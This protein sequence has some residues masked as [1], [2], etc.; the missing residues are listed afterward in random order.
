MRKSTMFLRLMG[1][2]FRKRKSRVAIALLAIVIGAAVI[3]G[4]VNVYYDINLK[5]SKEFRSYGANLIITPVGI[6]GENYIAQQEID[7]AV[8]MLPKGTLVGFAPYLY[9]VAQVESQRLV[10][11]GTWFDQ[12]SKVSPYWEVTG[13][14]LKERNPAGKALVG[15]A[16]AQKLDLAVGRELVLT[17]EKTGRQQ[18][19]MIEGIVKSGGT[20]DNQIFISLTQAQEL[21][22]QPHMVNVAYLS[23]MAKGLELE[24]KA[25]EIKGKF[26]GLEV[27]PIKQI[28]RSEAVIL[29]KIRSLVY[30]VVGIILLSTL[31]CVATTM[32]TMVVERKREIGLKKALGAQNRSIMIEFLS[33]G[34]ILGLAGGIVGISL[35][36]FLAQLIGQS[37]FNS[38]ITFRFSVIPLVLLVSLLVAGIACILPVKMAADVEPA[39]VLKGE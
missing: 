33:E 31:L 22:N 36:Y 7:Q 18:Q 34:S 8:G 17:D 30:L 32:M 3:S 28:S 25:K 1:S 37:V 13:T 29:E 5:M 35:G 6:S 24:T 15:A 10:V 9:G 20:E 2:S 38:A 4:L 14:W 19:V 26:A 21:F 23:V 11:V 12:V 16:V 39:V 27:R